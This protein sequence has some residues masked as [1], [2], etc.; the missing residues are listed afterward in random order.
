M[1]IKTWIE[2]FQKVVLGEFGER[3]LFIG[4]QGSQA[5]GEAGP[6]SDIDVVVIFD[7]L[8]FEDIKRYRQTVE[9]L[10]QRDRLCGFISG[11]KEIQNW[12]QSELFQFYYDTIS[13]YGSLDTLISFD[14]KTSAAQ[15]VHMGACA[16]YHGCV[17]N[18]LHGK[19]PAAL[20]MLCKSAIFVMQAEHFCRTGQHIRKHAEL[21]PLLGES[22]QKVLELKKDC[23]ANFEVLSELLMDWSAKR[24]GDY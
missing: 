20:E 16:I 1:D 9:G 5:R 15:A 8:S 12:E 10:P 24:I 6:D 2:Q 22:E 21:L 11:K 23:G 19:D 7:T 18:F 13:V 17:H 3:I 4:L 14:E